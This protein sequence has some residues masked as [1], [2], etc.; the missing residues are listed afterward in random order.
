MERKYED[1]SNLS[2]DATK[3]GDLS[4][5]NVVTHGAFASPFIVQPRE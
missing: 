5:R 2:H 4:I 1:Y 3:C